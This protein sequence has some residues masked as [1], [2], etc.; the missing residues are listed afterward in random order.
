MG[1]ARERDAAVESPWL[2][3]LRL[4]AEYRKAPDGFIALVEDFRARARRVVLL[5]E[6]RSNLEEAVALVPDVSKDCTR[7]INHLEDHCHE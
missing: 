3:N 7:N 2:W 6:S 4:T 5:E 1:A